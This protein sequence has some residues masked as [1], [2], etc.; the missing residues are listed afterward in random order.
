MNI[1]S[2]LDIEQLAKL[3]HCSVE[4][5][6]SNASRAPHRLPAILRLPGHKRLLWRRCDVD[7]WL[8]AALAPVS[9]AHSISPPRRRG[10]PT[11]AEQ[12]Q[13]AQREGGVRNGR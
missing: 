2:L 8:A 7:A 9:A 11:K 10:R 13:R 3:L 12:R 5:V 6:R 1:T 4:T